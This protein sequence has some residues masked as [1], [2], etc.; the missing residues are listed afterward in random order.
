MPILNLGLPYAACTSPNC[1]KLQDLRRCGGCLVVWYCGTEHQHADR[2]RHKVSCNIV[3]ESRA[4]LKEAEEALRACPGD[5]VAPGVPVDTAVGRFWL[6]ASTRPYMRARN[7]L[8]AALLNLRTGEATEEALGHFLDMLRLSRGDNLDVRHQVPALYL[9]LGQDQAAY[10]FLFFFAQAQRDKLE[11]F[12]VDEPFLNLEGMDAFRPFHG[13]F[14]PSELYLDLSFLVDLTLVKI[15]LWLDLTE[16][17]KAIADLGDKAP[18]D[19]TELVNEYAR[20]DVL[21]SRMDIVQRPD[22]KEVIADLWDQVRAMYAEVD[23]ANKYFWPAI[24]DPTPYANPAL[25]LY[26]RGSREE[27]LVKFRYAWY[28]WAETP[29]AVELIRSGKLRGSQ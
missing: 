2:P 27:V 24:V 19:R 10:D 20:S 26:T 29:G 28:S 15:R 11:W 17:D 7:D 4:A 1:Y 25:G 14:D 12:K 5:G 9:R 16:I 22:Y 18:E 8:A 23:K 13:E 3:K 21:L 6:V